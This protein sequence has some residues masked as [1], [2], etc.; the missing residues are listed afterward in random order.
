MLQN[1]KIVNNF[2][3]I[4]VVIYLILVFIGWLNIYSSSFDGDSFD[5]SARYGKQM[6]MIVVVVVL[7]VTILF[8]NAQLFPAFS[9]IF[10]AFIIFLLIMV[11]LI[12]DTTGGSKSWFVIGSFKIQP[13]EFAKLATALIIAKT[14]GRENFR[15]AKNLNQ[16]LIVAG[17]IFLPM[18]LI[19]L[20]G[21]AGS[22]LVFIAFIFVLYREGLS[23]W[24]LII[25]FVEILVF[26]AF[27][28]LDTY[29]IYTILTLAAL[30][31]HRYNT[32]NFKESIFAFLLII[33]I[34]TVQAA[35]V[36]FFRAEINISVMIVIS[37]LFVSMLAFIKYLRKMHFKAVIIPVLLLFYMSS[38]YSTA[39]V[40]K[41]ILKSHQQERITILFYPEKDISGVGYQTH[42]SK[43]AIGSGGFY[44][45][46]FLKGT[47]TKYDF[48]PEQDTD[49]IFCTVGEEWGFVGTTFVILLFTALIFRIIYLAERQKS[50][51]S[52]IFGY[53]L[54]LIIFLHYSVNIAMT[55]G[56]APVIGIP[57][58]FL[59]YGGSSLVSFSLFLFIFLRLDAER[60]SVFG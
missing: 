47:Q 26:I 20:Q 28:F 46:G 33:V 6:I 8:F 30:V 5:F 12:G 34:I 7:L 41:N 31:T 39:Y 3:W 13:S 25:L 11:L 4:T 2:D 42:Q 58:P 38:V 45:K 23:F 55:I 10:Y 22:A 15:L 52:R 57:L 51:F 1:S 35:I 43:I 21:D 37:V 59:S 16:F 40:Y 17:L 19:L 56:L 53:S 60:E 9:I 54:A 27:F 29:L 44:G 14:A 32:G 24:W 50:K 48:V 49:Y 18:F 36:V